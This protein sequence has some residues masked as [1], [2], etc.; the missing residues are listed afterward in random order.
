MKARSA[1]ILAVAC[2]AVACGANV[3]SE[4]DIYGRYSE[5]A[6]RDGIHLW[7]G[8]V[9]TID[10]DGYSHVRFTDELTLDPQPPYKEYRGTFEVVENKV[11]FSNSFLTPPERFYVE[12]EGDSYLL[13]TD[14][15]EMYTSTG[16]LPDWTLRKYSD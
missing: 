9:V 8:D 5:V 3:V 11:V 15:Y 13:R 4:N 2:V 6:L 12:V 16:Q 14:D 1:I 7:E 10:V